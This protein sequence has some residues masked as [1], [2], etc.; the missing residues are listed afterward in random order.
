MLARLKEIERLFPD[1]ETLL[2]FYPAFFHM[3][4]CM[5]ET[6][7]QQKTS[8]PARELLMSLI[9]NELSELETFSKVAETKDCP[10]LQ[11][12]IMYFKKMVRVS[13]YLQ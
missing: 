2:G 8:F 10:D 4:A 7:S 3:V 11:K 13:R 6:S 1:K 9:F 12:T 5:I